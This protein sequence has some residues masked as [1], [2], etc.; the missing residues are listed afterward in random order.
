MGAG[1][2][3][4]AVYSGVSGSGGH[5]LLL[6]HVGDGRAKAVAAVDA[7]VAVRRVV[8]VRVED[9]RGRVAV[10]ASV[11]VLREDHVGVGRVAA[12]AVLPDDLRRVRVRACGSLIDKVSRGWVFAR[13]WAARDRL[14]ALVLLFRRSW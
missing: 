3:E 8:I 9:G 10:A 2:C 11:V 14:L 1:A 6:L 4:K 13:E 12:H 5:S 7:R